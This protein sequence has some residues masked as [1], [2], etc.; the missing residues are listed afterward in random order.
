MKLKSFGCSFIFGSDLGDAVTEAGPDQR[1]S[2]STWPALMAKKLN[3]QYV[4][5]AHGG[6]GNLAI[7]DRL[8]N[9]LSKSEPAFFVINW[10]YI[11]RF[12]YRDLSGG[13]TTLNDWIQIRPGDETAISEMYFKNLHSEYRDKLTSLIAINTA[14]DVLE[15]QQRS[16]IMTNMD[17]LLLDDKFNIGPGMKILQDRIRPHLTSFQG[18]DFLSWSRAQGFLISEYNHPLEAAHAAAAEYVLNHCG[19]Q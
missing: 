11:D 13:P 7:L 3:H 14:L 17:D 15:K 2:L 9:Q 19:L 4:C 16:F 5:F 10:T 1:A 8:L 18:L 12:D 6:A